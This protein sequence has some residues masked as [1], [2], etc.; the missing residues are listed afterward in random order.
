MLYGSAHPEKSLEAQK[1]FIKLVL[2]AHCWAENN[3]SSSVVP[4]LGLLFL[5]R[6]GLGR[7]M[8]QGFTG[9]GIVIMAHGEEALQ[10]VS[11][12]IRLNKGHQLPFV[13]FLFSLMRA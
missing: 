5:P 4:F 13:F 3:S 6:R 12:N 2:S 11:V 9:V 1:S 8:R 7:K 10:L